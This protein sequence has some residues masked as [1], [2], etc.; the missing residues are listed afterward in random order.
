M[1]LEA[2]ILFRNSCTETYGGL[3]TESYPSQL[4]D[5]PLLTCRSDAQTKQNVILKNSP[6]FPFRN[7]RDIL[8]RF[9][10]ISSLRRLIDEVQYPPLL[11]LEHLDSNLLV[12]SA[13]KK[14][15]SPEVKRVAKAVL[16]R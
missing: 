6:D 16:K 7:E 14:L 10:N 13:T 1:A 3:C 5:T 9:R 2:I 15:Q 8:K 12:E 11:V 4:F